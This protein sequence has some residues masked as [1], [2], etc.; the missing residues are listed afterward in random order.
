MNV[1][2]MNVSD[3]NLLNDLFQ[4]VLNI[5]NEYIDNVSDGSYCWYQN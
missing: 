3:W 1:F 4:T 5:V 2:V